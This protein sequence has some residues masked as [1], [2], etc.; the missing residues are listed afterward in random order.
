MYISEL[1]SLKLYRQLLKIYLYKE[2]DLSI[3]TLVICAYLKQFKY[4]DYF[5]NC[6]RN[7]YLIN[8]CYRYHYIDL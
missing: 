5:K 7:G 1:C 3:S 2:N 8:Y 6:N 4:T